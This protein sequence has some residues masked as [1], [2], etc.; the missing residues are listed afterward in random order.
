M[1]VLL[2]VALAYIGL[3]V[4]P[5]WAQEW[6]V[7]TRFDVGR[8]YVQPYGWSR[9]DRRLDRIR[10]IAV[11]DA[12]RCRRVLVTYSDGTR[13]IVFSGRINENR[14]RLVR[15]GSFRRV[16]S[17]NLTCRSESVRAARVRVEV[18]YELP[19]V[20]DGGRGQ[21]VQRQRQIER[22]RAA[23]DGLYNGSDWA[24]IGRV[25]FGSRLEREVEYTDFPARVSELRLIARGSSLR[26]SRVFAT[27]ANGNTRE[28]FR[29]IIPQNGARTVTFR[30]DRVVRALTFI[31]QAERFDRGTLLISA[32]YDTG[33]QG[34]RLTRPGRQPFVGG[35]SWVRL[36]F[37]TF[38]RRT[39]VEQVFT[40]FDGPINRLGLQPRDD[41]ARCSRI[42]VTFANGRTRNLPFGRGVLEEGRLYVVDLPGDQRRIRRVTLVCQSFRANDSTIAI[43]GIRERVVEDFRAGRGARDLGPDWNRIGRVAF[44]PRMEREIKYTDFPGPVSELRLRARDSGIRCR[45]VVANFRDGSSR[46]VYAGVIPEGRAEIVAFRRE[47]FVTSMSFVCQAEK[48]RQGALVISSKYYD[49]AP[50]ARRGV[51]EGRGLRSAGRDWVRLGTL[52]F[53]RR[54][55]VERTFSRFEGPV[56]RLAIQAQDD[57]ARCSAIVVTFANGRSRSLPFGRGILEEGR[58][59]TVDLPG[60]QRRVEVITMRCRAVD[61]RDSYIAIFGIR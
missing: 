59:Y 54:G 5:A 18:A 30:R 50:V 55:E 23:R 4:C 40:R 37:V 15:F 3:S 28:I 39:E 36:G 42:F 24:R 31:C 9:F 35:A 53:N 58:L 45:R 46:T 20:R 29:G 12:V 52:R 26:C 8:D 7:I 2:I 25:S 14:F 49:G 47:R 60:D 56:R 38:R 10:L 33:P 41:D 34:N 21:T 17:I 16:R 32:R 51:P 44:G 11:G 43:Y 48:G 19:V 13:Q 22:L 61:A 6:T 27:F 1:R 57:P